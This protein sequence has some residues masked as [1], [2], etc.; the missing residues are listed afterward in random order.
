MIRPSQS[1]V[2]RVARVFGL[3]EM[4][5]SGGGLLDGPLRARLV[6]RYGDNV[7]AWLD[8]LPP[9][10]KELAHRW[11]V[12][13]VELIPR[14][15]MSVVIRCSTANGEGAVL[16]LCP[17]RDRVAREAAALERW[18][19]DRVVSVHRVDTGAGALLLEEIVPGTT[20][21]ESDSYPDAAIADLLQSIHRSG[22]HDRAHPHVR[23][24]IADLFAASHHHRQHHPELVDVV[25]P[26]LLERGRRLAHRLA[27][28]PAPTVLLHGD[29]T[30][31][32]VLDG[33][34]RGLV[35]IDPAP[36]LGDPAFDAIDLLCWNAPDVDTIRLRAETL[37]LATDGDP[38]RLF[39][40]CVA[41]AAM[42]ASELA[43]R[44]NAVDTS[45]ET[46][47]ALADIASAD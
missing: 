41:F 27:E 11:G 2:N 15:T 8:E 45:L 40:W 26:E 17:D 31:V 12:D 16:K 9:I 47:L 36:C 18:S 6:A 7:H 23:D 3:I 14:G 33:G 32:N 24:R 43:G 46:A 38:N 22:T 28:Q 19:T 10:L 4:D 13:L 42:T 20:L 39:E 25:P 29:L 5:A 30:P 44:P 37:A 35:A 21:A 34:D 1:S